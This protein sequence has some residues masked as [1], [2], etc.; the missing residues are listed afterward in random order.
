MLCG[1][2][3]RIMTARLPQFMEEYMKRY[4]KMIFLTLLAAAALSAC[5]PPDKEEAVTTYI[6]AFFLGEASF[7]LSGLLYDAGGAPLGGGGTL[8]AGLSRTPAWEINETLSG[9]GA[10]HLDINK[11]TQAVS[12]SKETVGDTANDI[13]R[14]YFYLADEPPGWETK[15]GEMYLALDGVFLQEAAEGLIF[16]YFKY[17]YVTEPLDLSGVLYG[18]KQI[19]DNIYEQDKTKIWI[20][21]CNFT[22]AGWYKVCYYY[23]EP[24]ET[25][26]TNS[27]GQNTSWKKIPEASF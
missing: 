22:K 25:N 13:F 20:Y 1:A 9:G 12:L 6:K 15:I 10:F 16:P 27:T 21:E 17:V 19:A 7:E 8:T 3:A 5:P 2:A 14:D 4:T 26:Q 24:V 23:N 18:K 11:D